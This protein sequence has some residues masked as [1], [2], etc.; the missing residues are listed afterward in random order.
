MEVVGR[1]AG[2]IAH[3]INNY[4]GAIMGFAELVKM[5]HGEDIPLS[6]K[7]DDIINSTYSAS[8]LIDQLLAYGKRQSA[9]PKVVNLN[10]IIKSMQQMME[11]LIGEDIDF[12]LFLADDLYNVKIDPSQVEQ[13]LVN[14]L[15]NARDA[16]PKG[17]KITIDTANA[18]F[19]DEHVMRHSELKTGKYV[20][21]G[22]SDTGT[23]IPDE[24]R[25]KI[26]EP[27]FTT[28]NK[29]KS[30]G[31]GLATIYGIVEQNGGSIEVKSASGSGATIAIFLPRCDEELTGSLDEKSPETRD[32]RGSEK[33]LFV[34]DN[35]DV[36]SSTKSLLDAMGYRVIVAA[37]G[38]EALNLFE[39]QGDD[40]DLI[41]TDVVMPGMSGKELVERIQGKKKKVAALFISG[42]DDDVVSLHGILQ[43]K[44][45]FLQKPFTSRD[46]AGKIKEIL[47]KSPL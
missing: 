21:L 23:G 39:D 34:E 31:L 38:L 24:I 28:K 35:D 14:L 5:K 26:F 22:V 4:L 19:F 40:I 30:S 20:K 15:I 43:E 12:S 47:Q 13:V 11:R 25:D 42:Y 45:H 1:L 18:E 17:G 2:G 27:F 37:N 7:M 6:Q 3:D 41:I 8:T 32:L 9:R 16:M 44:I 36:R 29:D 10:S 33:I 46:L